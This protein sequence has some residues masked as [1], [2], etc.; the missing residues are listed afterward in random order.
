LGTRQARRQWSN[1]FKVMKAENNQPKIQ[2]STQLCFKNK[3]IIKTLSEFQ[4][5]KA[6]I[7]TRLLLQEILKDILQVEGK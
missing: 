2:C 6:F 7:T 4:K 1:I 3:G 5:S